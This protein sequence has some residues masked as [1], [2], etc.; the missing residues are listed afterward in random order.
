MT[1]ECI[2]LL[3]PAAGT[4]RRTAAELRRILRP[5]HQPKLLHHTHGV[6]PEPALGDLA[7]HEAHDLDPGG[8]EAL[9]GGRN[10]H[11]LALARA[12]EVCVAD[13]LV[14][15]AEQVVNR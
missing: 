4:L 3:L 1:H 8:L 9:A 5:R 2:R 6:E 15:F 7:V 14:A 12:A 13:D 11:E 10:A